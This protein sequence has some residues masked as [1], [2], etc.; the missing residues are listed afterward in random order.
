MIYRGSRRRLSL[1]PKCPG[2]GK[3]ASWFRGLAAPDGFT[4]V[5]IVV[6]MVILSVAS[7]ALA[8]AMSTGYLGYRTL[9]KDMTALSLATAQMEFTKSPDTDFQTA[10]NTYPTITP[11]PPEGYDI[12]VTWEPAP[13]REFNDKLQ[14]ITVII[15]RNE[16]EVRRLQDYKA[17][18]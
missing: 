8:G 9:E 17:D 11:G 14:K 18:R 3:G 5:E 7:V 12:I 1:R 10:A 15:K 4:M 2:R 13:G 16:A 6:S